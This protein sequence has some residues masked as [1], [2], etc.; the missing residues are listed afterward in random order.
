MLSSDSAFLFSVI[1]ASAI[2][3][4]ALSSS[5]RFS[6]SVSVSSSVLTSS[7]SPIISVKS[8]FSHCESTNSNTFCMRSSWLNSTNDC[9]LVMRALPVGKV[10]SISKCIS[11]PEL[12]KPCSRC[13]ASLGLTKILM[14]S[15]PSG[16]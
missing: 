14:F 11:R 4:S 8:S 10:S 16:S 6:F 13:K 3:S 5:T 1:A 9:L 12:L 7:C 2:S 15:A